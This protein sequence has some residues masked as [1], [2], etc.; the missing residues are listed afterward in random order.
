MAKK[1]QLTQEKIIRFALKTFS[2]KGYDGTS[3]KEIASLSQVSEGTL[4]KY[5]K[6]KEN[7]FKLIL[8]QLVE[9]YKKKSKEE[10][11]SIIKDQ[12]SNTYETLKAV[13]E[14]RIDFLDKNNLAIKIMHQEAL[15]NDQLKIILQHEVW[16]TV[17]DAIDPI[18]EEAIIRKE[19][20]DLPIDYLTSQFLTTMASPVIASFMVPD[21]DHMKRREIMRQHFELFYQT[22]KL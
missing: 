16:P 15:I 5:F 22:I 2:N 7:L 10:V 8:G 13:L 20:K 14:N 9:L 17:K 4:F 19:I 21:I 3:T 11:E 1:S 18:F 6:S 12:S